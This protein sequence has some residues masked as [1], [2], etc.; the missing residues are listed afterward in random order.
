MNS[1]R[2]V[3]IYGIKKET[4]A[5]IDKYEYRDQEETD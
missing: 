4:I 2:M 1:Q 3:S 5:N